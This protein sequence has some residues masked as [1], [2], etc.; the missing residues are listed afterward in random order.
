KKAWCRVRDRQCELL[1]ETIGGQPQ[2]SYTVE[3]R[4]GTVTIVDD[5]YNAIVTITMTNLQA[6]DSGTY[7]CA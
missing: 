3:A 7:S 5:H 1:V 4:K 6:E 2:H